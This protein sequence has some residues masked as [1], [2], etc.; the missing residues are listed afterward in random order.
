MKSNLDEQS[1]MACCLPYPI[2]VLLYQEQCLEA[3]LTLQMSVYLT[4]SIQV[5]SSKFS[6]TSYSAP[7]G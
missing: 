7:R 5:E 1:L 2:L 3:P 4:A 6:Q